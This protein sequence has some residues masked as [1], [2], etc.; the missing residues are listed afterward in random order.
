M[1][2]RFGYLNL[3]TSKEFGNWEY[4]AHTKLQKAVQQNLCKTTPLK[5]T[6][7]WFSRPIL[8]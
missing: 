6:E 8:T 4:Q 5:K 7:N 3:C 1:C 2:K